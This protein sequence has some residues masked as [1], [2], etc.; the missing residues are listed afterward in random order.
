MSLVPNGEFFEIWCKVC[1]TNQSRLLQYSDNCRDYTS[2]ILKDSNSIINQI[3]N[4]L[5]SQYDLRKYPGEYYYTDA[6]FCKQID[7]V[8]DLP[9][10][11]IW[12]PV[13]GTWIRKIRIAFE[14]E[15]LIDHSYQEIYHLATL[16]AETKVL[17]TYPKEGVSLEQHINGF[18]KIIQQFDARSKPFL[19]IFGCYN[20]STESFDWVGY[21]LKKDKEPCPY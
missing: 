10:N 20:K 16:D 21:E 7:F 11:L 15:N 6:V 5:S 3:E 14:H 19:I 18:D 2:I 17:V 1:K 4:I 9:E 13:T 8:D 12:K